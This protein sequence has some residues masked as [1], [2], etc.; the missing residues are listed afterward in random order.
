MRWRRPNKGVWQWVYVA[1]NKARTNAG[2]QKGSKLDVEGEVE[3][4]IGIGMS[5]GCTRKKD[6]GVQI[7]DGR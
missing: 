1:A 2:K 6:Q 3:V 7:A 4:G 5:A